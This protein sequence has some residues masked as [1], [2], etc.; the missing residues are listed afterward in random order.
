MLQLCK[1]YL[2]TY[3]IVGVP[4]V[5]L[6]TIGIKRLLKMERSRTPKENYL[7][8]FTYNEQEF[9]FNKAKEL[10]SKHLDFD[11]SVDLDESINGISKVCLNNPLTKNALNGK[12]MLDLEKIV[13]KLDQQIECKGVILYGA[14]GNFCSGGDLN[15]MKQ[16]N[17]PEMG[18]AM[19]TYMNNILDKFKKLPMITVA[20]IE[21]SGALGGGAELTTACDY[22]LMSTKMETTAIGFIHAKMGIVPAWGSTGRLMSIMGRQNTLNLLLDS[23]P[24]RAAEAMDIGLVDGTVATLQ[25]ATD[26]LSQKTRHHVNVIRAIKRTLS[27]H[28][29]GT[30]GR[31]AALMERKIFAPLWGGP[32]NQMALD[33]YFSRNK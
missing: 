13:N 1:I 9:S 11:G 26:W 32:A 14:D 18:Y 7:H 19:A 15:M 8:N 23:R 16:M 2:G 22:R 5:P 29:D 33:Q 6:R 30:D 25:D 21:G 20:F 27:C 12:M 24:L 4:G 31:A 17:N 28:D 3:K 10:M